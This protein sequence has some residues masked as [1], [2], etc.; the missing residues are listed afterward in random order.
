MHDNNVFSRV[1]FAN[2]TI[3]PTTACDGSSFTAYFVLYK[4]S[5]TDFPGCGNIQVDGFSTASGVIAQHPSWFGLTSASNGGFTYFDW[6]L[7]TNCT[8]QSMASDSVIL[9]SPEE[10]GSCLDVGK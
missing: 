8:S 7:S 6:K 10:N 9:V 1:P 2:L 5:Q 4:N 3:K